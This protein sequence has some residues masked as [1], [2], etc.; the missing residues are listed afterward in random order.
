MNGRLA[1]PLRRGREQSIRERIERS[2]LFDRAWYL[3]QYPGVLRSGTDPIIDYVRHGAEQGRNPNPLFEGEWYLA[4]HP[5]AGS[6]GADALVHYIAHGAAAGCDPGP[7]F[8]S[9]RPSCAPSG[10][11]G[12]ARQSAGPLSGAGREQQGVA[13]R[14]RPPSQRRQGRRHC[15]PLLSRSLG[16]DCIPAAKHPNRFRPIRLAGAGECRRVAC[17][18]PARLS[19]GAGLSGCPMPDATSAPS[20]P[21]CQG[22]SPAN[23]RCCASCTARKGRNI[24]MPGAI[25][26]SQASSPTRC[27]CAEFC[28]P[29]PAIPSSHWR[30]RARSTFPAIPRSRKTGT[31]S[32]PSRGCS[33][34]A[35]PFL[36]TGDSLPARCSGRAPI[37]FGRSWNAVTAFRALKATTPETMVRSLTPW[38]AR[39]VRLRYCKESGSA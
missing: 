14:S 36:A 16:R 6:A 12:D 18:R 17:A 24:P 4:R 23:T 1:R 13:F 22:C 30:E 26:C 29:L 5:E 27:W 34:R 15:A 28:T 37:S 25:C 10:C 8:D 2:G 33:V 7:F 20:L 31:R 11:G 9:K 38:N 35:K 39:S 19:P 3:R 32:R 21:S